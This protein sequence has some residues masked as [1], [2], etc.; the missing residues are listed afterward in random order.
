VLG[1]TPTN[2]VKRVL[3]VP[4]DRC[5]GCKGRCPEKYAREEPITGQ[6]AEVFKGQRHQ[7]EKADGATGVVKADLQTGGKGGIRT[8]EGVQHPLPA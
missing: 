6:F 3:K 1:G 7:A 5:T 8:L 4:S 2:S